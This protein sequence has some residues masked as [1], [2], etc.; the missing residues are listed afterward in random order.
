MNI[1]YPQSNEEAAAVITQAARDK[2]AVIPAGHLTVLKDDPALGREDAL[3][4]SARDLNGFA[5]EP[6]NLLALAGAGLSADMVAEK[7]ADSGLYW[8]VSGLGS[9]S[10]GAIMA[11]GL[12]GLET[13]ARGSMTDWVLGAT[14]VTAEGRVVASGGRTL[15]NVSGYDFTR[16]AWRARG[17]LGLSAAFILKLLPCPETAPVLEIGLPGPAQAAQLAEQ[18]IR[19]RLA[20]EALRLIWRAGRASLLVWLAGFSELVEHKVRAI[21]ALP[22]RE[23]LTRHEDGFAFWRGAGQ[24]LEAGRPGLAALLGPRR[25]V[26]T[27]AG[28]LDRPQI[29]IDRADL[30]IGGGRVL[31]SPPEGRELSELAAT[32]GLVVDRYVSSGPVYERLRK[33]LDPAGLFFPDRLTEA[34]AGGRG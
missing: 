6:E 26:L 31:L 27:L 21:E 19:A 16:L 22:G 24:P 20:P 9:R 15:K 4:I 7:L 23:S 11:E 30:D 25:A 14:F 10:L 18:I 34:A 3:A 8:P 33:R 32:A 28:E 12:L 13:M 2:L 1:K 17:R 5:V 29:Q